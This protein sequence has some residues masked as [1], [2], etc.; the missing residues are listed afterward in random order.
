MYIDDPIGEALNLAPLKTP[1]NLEIDFSRCTPFKGSAPNIGE[2]NPMYGQKHTKEAKLKMSL[3][4]KKRIKEGKHP[5]GKEHCKKQ[6]LE[7]RHP[8]QNI[9][10]Q[11]E[12]G[13]KGGKSKSLLKLALLKKV[14]HLSIVSVTCPHCGK[15]GAKNIMHRWHLDNCKFKQLP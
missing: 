4:N 10:L 11:K 7:G 5:F 6:M 13:R 8:T 15:I 3:A 1:M 9:E 2:K 12:K 14:Q